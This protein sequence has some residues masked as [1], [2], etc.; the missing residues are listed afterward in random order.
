MLKSLASKVGVWLPNE[1]ASNDFQGNFYHVRV[2]IDVRKPLWSVVSL[3]RAGKRELFL[4]KH[5]RLLNWCQVCGHLGHE[6]KDHGDGI[7]PPQALIYKNSERSVVCG[8]RSNRRRGGARGSGRGGFAG[9]GS[10]VSQSEPDDDDDMLEDE[11]SK[12]RKRGSNYNDLALLEQTMPNIGDGAIVPADKSNVGTI[13]TL[14]K[15]GAPP[16][17]PALALSVIP[18]EKDIG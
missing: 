3:V 7:H 11:A 8:Q 15:P 2:K 5:E 17:P 14:F 4:V 12:G 10:S 9:R 13:V 6:F 1:G 18:S 16:P